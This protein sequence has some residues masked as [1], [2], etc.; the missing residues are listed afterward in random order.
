M[1]CSGCAISNIRT[2]T[3]HYHRYIIS[4]ALQQSDGNSSVMSGIHLQYNRAFV[5]C[6]APGFPSLI[7]YAAIDAERT[8]R[9]VIDSDAGGDG[10]REARIEPGDNVFKRAPHRDTD[11]SYAETCA[12][13]ERSVRICGMMFCRAFIRVEWNFLFPG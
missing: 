13:D 7:W 9:I 6:V 1:L 2:T 12:R 5:P 10:E 3:S 11:P 4:K 8:V